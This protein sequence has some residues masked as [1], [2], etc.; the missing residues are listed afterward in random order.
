M[1]DHDKGLI[2]QV[3]DAL[4]MGDDHDDESRQDPIDVERGAGGD[5]HQDAGEPLG[6]IDGAT[7]ASGRVGAAGGTGASGAM[8]GAGAGGPI[9]DDPGTSIG[10]R[11]STAPAGGVRTE[12][13]MG[14]EFDPDHERFAESG[15][16][17]ERRGD[18]DVDT[19]R[20]QGH[21]S[22][23]SS[24]GE[25]ASGESPFGDGSSTDPQERT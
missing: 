6:G 22:G 10:D 17:A 24:R 11:G 5:V 21:S 23:A 13:E 2:D 12:Y 20:D 1:S 3:K 14:R 19:W 15:V 8:G 4:G 9:G 16:M 18:A 7:Q 25:A